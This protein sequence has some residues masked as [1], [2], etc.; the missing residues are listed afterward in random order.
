MVSK[1]VLKLRKEFQE[2]L[3]ERVRLFNAV[4]EG[5]LRPSPSEHAKDHKWK[6]LR[7]NDG[8][9]YI[10]RPTRTVWYRWR[11][12]PDDVP[13]ATSC[14]PIT[15][16]RA[17]SDL[18]SARSLLVCAST[19][20]RSTRFPQMHTLS[21]CTEVSRRT[22]RRMGGRSCASPHMGTISSLHIIRV[23]AG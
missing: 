22:S 15:E 13:I 2:R 7:G 17:R 18:I 10:S 20:M 3:R 9:G 8:N 23:V 11:D 16:R 4:K 14:S 6:E 5:K 1:R 12:G 19:P 21:P